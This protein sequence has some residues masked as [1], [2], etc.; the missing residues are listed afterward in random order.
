M[1]IKINS[2]VKLPIELEEKIQKWANYEIKKDN[3]EYDWYY[4]DVLQHYEEEDYML[5]GVMQEEC[6]AE[7]MISI[8][9]DKLDKICL[10]LDKQKRKI[11]PTYQI[12]KTY[13]MKDN[14]N[15]MYKIGKSKNPKFREKTLQSEK[16][17]IKMIK[18]FDFN[19][20]RKLHILYKN[21]RVRGEWFRLSDKDL[22]NICNIQPT[23]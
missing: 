10:K 11:K 13:I 3:T 19:I 4:I 6:F 9:N 7:G 8:T 16:P 17:S 14:H 2:N 18:V 12:I 1:K 15:N 20:E 22:E 21:K 23:E 5:F